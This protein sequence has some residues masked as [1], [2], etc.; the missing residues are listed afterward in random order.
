M[1][2]LVFFWT[3]HVSGKKEKLHILQRNDRHQVFFCCFL[4]CLPPSL[5]HIQY[6]TLISHSLSLSLNLSFSLLYSLT[7]TQAWLGAGALAL[8]IIIVAPGLPDA[9]VVELP[10]L[11]LSAAPT[12]LSLQAEKKTAN[13]D[14]NTTKKKK[15]AV[16]VKNKQTATSSKK[17][18]KDTS[19]CDLSGL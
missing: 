3:E 13:T 5:V 8:G 2:C 15:T 19:G 11:S 4:S 17:K 14:D 7:E 1:R 9:V 12:L 10:S 18:L 6:R 16:V